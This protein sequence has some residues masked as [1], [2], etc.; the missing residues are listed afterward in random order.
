MIIFGGGGAVTGYLVD[1][2]MC[3]QIDNAGTDLN[4]VM[5]AQDGLT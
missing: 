1:G 2:S 4:S 5:A 3:L